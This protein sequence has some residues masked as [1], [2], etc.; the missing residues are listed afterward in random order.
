LIEQSRAADMVVVG[1]WGTGGISDWLLG[2]VSHK[3][4]QLLAAAL[5]PSAD[6]ASQ[7]A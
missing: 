2:S 6:S 3:V 1:A 7:R 4:A 5:Q